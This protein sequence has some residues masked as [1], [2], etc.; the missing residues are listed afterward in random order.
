[1]LSD[2]LLSKS[3]V[4]LNTKCYLGITSTR[5][6][7]VDRNA[8]QRSEQRLL[9]SSYH[10]NSSLRFLSVSLPRLNETAIREELIFQVPEPPAAPAAAPGAPDVSQ[11]FTIPEKPSPVDLSVLGEPSLDSL[12]LAS[13]WPPGRLQY[14]LELV[15]QLSLCIRNIVS[16]GFGCI[17][18]FATPT[19]RTYGKV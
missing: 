8:G 15:S 16:G 9:R 11:V 5:Q 7:S 13:Y 1:M 10:V 17:L 4:R 6:F 3:I 19:K 12:G 2:M 18:H 14:V